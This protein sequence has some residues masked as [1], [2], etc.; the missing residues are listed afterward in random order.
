MII[1]NLRV[2]VLSISIYF[3]ENT[4]ELQGN[5]EANPD[6]RSGVYIL[7]SEKK[8]ERM[9]CDMETNGGGWTLVYSYKSKYIN[10]FVIDVYIRNYALSFFYKY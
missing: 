2:G 3:R 1:P 4:H 10:F 7:W 5:S 8:P 9:L 6:A